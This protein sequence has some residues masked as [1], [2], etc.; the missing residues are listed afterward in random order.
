MIKYNM[1]FKAGVQYF[2]AMFRGEEVA[3]IVESTTF[4]GG[5][6]VVRNG[7]TVHFSTLEAAQNYIENTVAYKSVVQYNNP[8]KTNHDYQLWRYKMARNLSLIAQVKGEQRR[9]TERMRVIKE[10]QKKLKAEAN[11]IK[12]EVISDLLDDFM[13]EL[14]INSAGGETWQYDAYIAGRYSHDFTKFVAR[15]YDNYIYLSEGHKIAVRA[16]N[17]AKRA[18]N[19][20]FLDAIATTNGRDRL[21]RIASFK[22]LDR[23]E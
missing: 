15:H 8:S 7:N 20:A 12:E 18:M 19:K 14:G 22:N 23:V 1:R 13:A 2:V 6:N 11:C 9:N 21:L 10:E 17:S 5:W 4:T 3:T 16:F